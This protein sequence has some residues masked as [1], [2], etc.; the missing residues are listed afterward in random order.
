LKD[1]LKNKP[2]DARLLSSAFRQVGEREV[3]LL[4][5]STTS[6][7]TS[8]TPSHEAEVMTSNAST[9]I[10]M[11]DAAQCILSFLKSETKPITREEAARRRELARPFHHWQADSDLEDEENDEDV[12]A[13]GENDDDGIGEDEEGH[14]VAR[15]EDNDDGSGG[16]NDNDDKVSDGN[17]DVD[18]SGSDDDN[19][20]DIMDVTGNNNDDANKE[21]CIKVVW[22]SEDCFLSNNSDLEVWSESS[23]KV[24]A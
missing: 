10:S 21:E 14:E 5:S 17:K 19:D 4:L 20:D 9:V 11:E 3:S 23:Q 22:L 6:A 16:N 13:D 24:P 12:S 2:H 1:F 7:T 8:T 15:D 18:H